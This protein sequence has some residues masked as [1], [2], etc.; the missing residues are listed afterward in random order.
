MSPTQIVALVVTIRRDFIIQAE[1]GEDI[2]NPNNPNMQLGLARANPTPIQNQ[3][4]DKSQLMETDSPCGRYSSWQEMCN[5][6]TNI[7]TGNKL[8]RLRC[9]R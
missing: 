3:R 7:L 6:W 5:L 2:H 1:S 9:D 4:P 8:M